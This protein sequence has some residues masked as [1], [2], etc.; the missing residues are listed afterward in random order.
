MSKSIVKYLFAALTI[1]GLAAC[2]KEDEDS[3]PAASERYI[4]VEVQASL[5]GSTDS[6]YTTHSHGAAAP[7]ASMQC[8]PVR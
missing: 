2:S 7:P 6:D 4:S 5:F 3:L 8:L 1:A